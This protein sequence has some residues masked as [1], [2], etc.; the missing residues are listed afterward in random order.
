M[1]GFLNHLIQYVNVEIECIN[2]K[3][4]ESTEAN[5]LNLNANEVT[6]FTWTASKRALLELIYALYLTVSINHGKVSFKELVGFFSHIFNISLPG[7]HTKIKKMTDR[8]AQGIRIESRSFFLDEM[9]IK[10]N[11]KLELLDEN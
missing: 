7:Y 4:N 8:K 2:I 10:F 5:S 9:V 3:K 11:N 6:P 1:H